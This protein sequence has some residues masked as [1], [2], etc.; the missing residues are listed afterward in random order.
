MIAVKIS[1][2]IEKKK[3]TINSREGRSKYQQGV[4]KITTK[5]QIGYGEP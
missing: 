3:T 4:L 1:D 2:K 5:G